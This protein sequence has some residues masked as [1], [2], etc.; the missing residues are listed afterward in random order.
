MRCPHPL[1]HTA[2]RPERY[3]ARFGAVNPGNTGNRRADRKFQSC[4]RVDGGDLEP[5]D[6]L[7][8][9]LAWLCALLCG[10]VRRALAW[11]PGASLRA[12]FCAE[13]LAAAVGAAVEVVAA[14][15]DLRELDERPLSRANRLP[16]QARPTVE[17]VLREA[18]EKGGWVG[19]RRL[20]WRHYE[21]AAPTA[22]FSPLLPS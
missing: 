10:D 19:A 9:G 11:C 2:P 20:R 22:R 16:S 15:D 6:G 12:G 4:N 13:A 1:H 14:A 18:R 17:V 5:G 8:G 21:T 7:R 3:P